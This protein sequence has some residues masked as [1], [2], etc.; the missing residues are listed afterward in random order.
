MLRM[1]ALC[2]LA[3]TFMPRPSDVA[4][5]ACHYNSATEHVE[6][7][8]FSVNHITFHTDGSMSIKFHGIKNDYDRDG[9]CVTLPVTDPS[10]RWTLLFVFVCIY[11]VPVPFGIPFW[12]SQC[13]LL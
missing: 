10:F 6:K 1:K 8:V 9:F 13:F 7:M 11:N 4:P 5:N 2:L 3:L 12:L